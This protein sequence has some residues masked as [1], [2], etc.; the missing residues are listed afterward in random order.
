MLILIRYFINNSVFIF[1][2]RRIRRVI[3]IRGALDIDEVLVCVRQV[4]LED[5]KKRLTAQMACY[6]GGE[7]DAFAALVADATVTAIHDHRVGQI[8]EADAAA[9]LLEEV[10][11]SQLRLLLGFDVGE[12]V[13]VRIVRKLHV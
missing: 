4:H 7:K 13:R 5:E 2:I 12:G 8:A 11:V 3:D 6:K 1:F 9:G 10:L